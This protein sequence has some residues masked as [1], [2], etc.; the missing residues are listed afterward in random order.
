MRR[1]LADRLKSLVGRW[2]YRC[3]MCNTRFTGPQDAESIA[4]EVARQEEL[5]RPETDHEVP[6]ET[7]DSDKTEADKS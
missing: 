5:A 7:A 6:E 3:Q 2:P 1:T 4:R